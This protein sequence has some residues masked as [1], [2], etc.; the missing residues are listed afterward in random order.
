M[1]GFL[2]PRLLRFISLLRLWTKLRMRTHYCRSVAEE[3]HYN[4]FDR[5]LLSQQPFCLCFSWM[6]FL[7]FRFLVPFYVWG[8]CYLDQKRF[9]IKLKCLQQHYKYFKIVCYESDTN[10]VKWRSLRSVGTWMH[11]IFRC[12]LKLYCKNENRGYCFAKLIQRYFY[13]LQKCSFFLTPC[14]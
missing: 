4:W 8:V 7:C 13:F 3:K 1:R 5:P 14:S 2:A 9:W 11:I 12:S 10:V 6:Y